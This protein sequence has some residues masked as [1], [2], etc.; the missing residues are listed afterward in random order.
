LR[1]ALG[2]SG[3]SRSAG[4]RTIN[5]EALVDFIGL[6]QVVALTATDVDSVPLAFT[7]CKPGDGSS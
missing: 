7:E 2:D 5:I 1:D 3:F 4:R 6:D